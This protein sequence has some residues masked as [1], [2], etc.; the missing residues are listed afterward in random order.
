MNQ[1]I[2][3]KFDNVLHIAMPTGFQIIYGWS[4][5]NYQTSLQVEGLDATNS[6]NVLI[7]HE[8]EDQIA[9]SLANMYNKMF[10]TCRS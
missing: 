10:P 8:P 3:V 7:E 2:K 1:K 9:K 6:N 5:I 4:K